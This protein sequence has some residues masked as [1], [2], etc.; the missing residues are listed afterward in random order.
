[1]A[2]HPADRII[3][4]LDGMAPE[5]ALAFMGLGLM[6]RQM[7]RQPFVDRLEQLLE[8]PFHGEDGGAGVDRAAVR[9]GD[10][11]HLAARGGL[12]LEDGDAHAAAQQVERGGQAPDPRPDHRD[13]PLSH[14]VHFAPLRRFP[15]PRMR[16]VIETRQYECLLYMTLCAVQGS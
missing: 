5:Q 14:A 13:M 12:P 3:V 15:D 6:Q 4:A 7:I 9:R 1:M 8:H 10:G 2:M 11:A 16:I